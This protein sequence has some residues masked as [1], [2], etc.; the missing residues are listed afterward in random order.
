MR[1]GWL[2][3][4]GELVGYQIEEKALYLSFLTRKKL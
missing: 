3:R 4:I 1:S 2:P